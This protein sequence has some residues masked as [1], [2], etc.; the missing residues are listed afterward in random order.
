VSA[1]ARPALALSLTLLARVSAAQTPPPSAAAPSAAAPSAPVELQGLLE[2]DY[3]YFTSDAEGYAGLA[4]RRARMG[5]R[6]RPL[7]WLDLRFVGEYARATAGILDAFA[8]LRAGDELEVSAGFFRM[9]TMPSGRDDRVFSLPIPERAMTVTALWPNRDLGVEAHWF[10]KR[11][12]L[13]VWAR[14]G[15]GSGN[16][17]G[18]ESSVPT[19]ALRVDLALGR[20][21]LHAPR[22]HL[23]GLRVG[24]AGLVGDVLDRVGIAGVT[25]LGFQ[26]YRPPSIEGLRATVTAHLRAWVGAVQLSI[27]G[28]VARDGRSRDTDGNPATPR[29]ALDPVYTWGAVGELAWMVS[30]HRRVA[31][32]W[33]V[34]ERDGWMPRALGAW[35]LSARVE[36][37]T[38][39]DMASDVQPGGVWG[40]AAALRWWANRW[41]ALALAGYHHRFD[42]API[43]APDTTSSW[44]LLLR[45]TLRVP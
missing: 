16:P 4:L 28:G 6:A 31:G 44:S 14:F 12:P 43:E 3:R 19:G 10:P 41:A 39:S 1:R 33:P 32:E 40:F 8:T 22:D 20:A 29:V 13:E 38:L 35:E 18:P 15:N 45:G 34:G 9:P 27:E 37:L 42:R 7:P 17:L 23:W 36:R 30:G 26:F 5:L 25:P 2:G 11:V 24:V 21:N